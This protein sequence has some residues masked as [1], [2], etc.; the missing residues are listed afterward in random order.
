M[1][2]FEYLRY[3]CTRRYISLPKEKPKSTHFSTC[4]YSYLLH[5][6]AIGWHP[7]LEDKTT[8]SG[9]HPRRINPGPTLT[10]LGQ[11]IHTQCMRLQKVTRRCAVCGAWR[12]AGDRTRRDP[13][14]RTRQGG[15]RDVNRRVRLK[16]RWLDQREGALTDV[17][18]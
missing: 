15:T 12:F 11:R 16:L 8:L 6:G 7:Y 9:P 13:E 1:E 17:I 10:F 2:C 4:F 14:D 3:T 5:A 18:T